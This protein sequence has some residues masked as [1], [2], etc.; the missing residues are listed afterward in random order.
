MNIAQMMNE[1]ANGSAVFQR[2]PEW[3]QSRIGKLTASRMADAMSFKRNGEQTKKRER[4]MIEL[5][6]ERQTD[7]IVPHFVTDAMA[8]GMEKEAEAKEAAKKLLCLEIRE[9]G[10]VDHPEID[11]FGASPDGGLDD[12]GLIEIKCPETTTHMRYLANN[13]IPEDRKPQMI[14][15]LLCTG[16]RYCQFMS[17]DPRFAAR[18]IFYKRF[19]PT[20]QERDAV[21]NAAIRFLQDAE[22]LF[23][24]V[25]TSHRS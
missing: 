20:Q 2:T 15:Q 13:V 17:Y 9:Y 11:L 22:R 21:E 16:R 23:E 1:T 5:V 19:A 8:W 18:P 12:D 25:T 4:Y 7:I 10:F 6:A 14:A 24:L 3:Y